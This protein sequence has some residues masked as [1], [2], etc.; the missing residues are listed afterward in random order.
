MRLRVSALDQVAAARFHRTAIRPKRSGLCGR[1]LGHAPSHGKATTMLV[2]AH[3][4]KWGLAAFA[5]KDSS[6]A[7]VRD[8]GNRRKQADH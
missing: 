5:A 6:A 4:M 8:C 3:T 1:S 7:P 2:K